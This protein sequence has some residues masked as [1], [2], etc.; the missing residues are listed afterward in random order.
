MDEEKTKS[1]L[2]LHILSSLLYALPFS[3]LHFFESQVARQLSPSI[4]SINS[5]KIHTLSFKHVHRVKCSKIKYQNLEGLVL[6]FSLR[7]QIL[8]VAVV[9]SI[10]SLFNSLFNSSG[11][12]LSHPLLTLLLQYIMFQPSTQSHLPLLNQSICPSHGD[13]LAKSARHN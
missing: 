5:Y 3:Y 2:Y 6:G 10:A 9:F 1:S 13:P 11:L 4:L 12:S 7:A 8:A